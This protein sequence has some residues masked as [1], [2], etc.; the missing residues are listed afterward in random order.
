MI[1]GVV[2]FKS[3][4]GV[5]QTLFMDRVFNSLLLINAVLHL[6]KCAYQSLDLADLA[7]KSS[8]I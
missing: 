6:L 4:E 2:L 5:G 7:I 1:D 3:L 8:G